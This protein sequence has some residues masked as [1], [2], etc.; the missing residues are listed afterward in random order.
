ML[1]LGIL[2]SITL[3]WDFFVSFLSIILID[4]ILA[5]DNAVVI[6]M[7]VRTLPGKQRLKGIAF[8]AGAAV[9]L[10]IVLTF[11]AAQLLQIQF[12]KLVGGI[13]IIWIAVKLF[14]EGTP[15]EG[16]RVAKTLWQ[17]VWIIVIA[18]ITMSTDN[19][20]AVAATSKGNLFL[21]IFGLGLSIPFVVFTSSL[22]SR[23]MDR[24]PVIVYVGAAILG[25]VGGE[26]MI[27]DP[28]IVRILQPSKYFQYGVE[29]F[30]TLAVI[31]AGML[32]V[33]I[34]AARRRRTGSGR[35]RP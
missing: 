27:T 20:L 7:A 19:V 12:V 13:L 24:Y 11:F 28:F 17:A 29:I 18:D 21:L 16:Y 3:N 31:T 22:L 2:G 32:W 15:E 23:L 6:A 8:G 5:G 33:R 10:R 9:I 14:V 4:L 35:D 34:L 1:D 25:R 26:M 30:F